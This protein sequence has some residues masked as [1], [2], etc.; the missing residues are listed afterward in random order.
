[1]N[2]CQNLLK[3]SVDMA[4]LKQIQLFWTFHPGDSGALYY[5]HILVKLWSN[6]W[7][8]N[9]SA[10]F[11]PMINSFIFSCLLCLVRSLCQTVQSYKTRTIRQ[12][13]NITRVHFAKSRQIRKRV[14]LDTDQDFSAM[15]GEFRLK[16]HYK[17]PAPR[18][19]APVTTKQNKIY[20]KTNN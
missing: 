4:K 2:G 5:P 9:N 8:Q 20:G 14:L 19:P 11:A 13:T 16:D 15:R 7:K 17:L 10:R 12:N 1:M 3:E 6:G 18:P